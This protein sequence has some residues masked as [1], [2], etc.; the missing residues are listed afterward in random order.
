[1]RALASGAMPSC[2]RQLAWIA[3][4][5]ALACG[6]ALP[7]ETP[8]AD[9]KPPNATVVLVHGMGSFH[10][11]DVDYFYRVP[12]LYRSLGAKVLVPSIAAFGSIEA[13]AAAIQREL[14]AV[15]GPLVLLG[16]SQ[17]GLDA[18]WLVSRL[19][20]ANRVRAVVT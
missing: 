16:H 6:G 17:G 20:Y 18:R 19:G 10:V 13:R 15:P 3:A 4:S 5:F 12:Q 1:M 7:Q 14:D 8:V 9:L 2:M 11:G